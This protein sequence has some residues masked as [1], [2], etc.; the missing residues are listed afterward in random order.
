MLYYCL[1]TYFYQDPDST[2]IDVVGKAESA[3]EDAVVGAGGMKRFSNAGAPPIAST[4]TDAS[5]AK[6]SAPWGQDSA[7]IEMNLLEEETKERAKQRDLEKGAEASADQ[8]RP[9]SPAS[10]QVVP[11][12]DEEARAPSADPSSVQVRSERSRVSESVEPEREVK[13]EVDGADAATLAAIKAEEADDESAHVDIMGDDSAAEE[14]LL[15]PQPLKLNPLSRTKPTTAAQKKASKSRTG[16]AR[17]SV[18]TASPLSPAASPGPSNLHREVTQSGNAST[19]DSTREGT[20]ELAIR[21]GVL[22]SGRN[23][24]APQPFAFPKVA[25]RKTE[26]SREIGLSAPF[27]A[28]APPR[29]SDSEE[30]EAKSGRKKGKGRQKE[31]EKE[32]EEEEEGDD[33][34][35]CICQQL[36]DSDRSMIACDKCENWYHLDCIGIPDDKVDLVDQ[37]ICPAYPKEKTTWKNACARPTCLRAVAPL[38]KY[39]SD[40]CGIEVAATR[41][42]LSGIPP[43]MLWKK[44]VGARRREAVVIDATRPSRGTD[45]QEAARHQDAEDERLLRSLRAK[46][47]E[48]VARRGVLDT[49]VAL[50]EARL[51]YLRVAIK[52]WEQLC[53]ETAKAIAEDATLKGEMEAVKSKSKGKGKKGP[54][55]AMSGPGAQCG[56]DV[57]LCLDSAEWA[58][59]VES[60]EGR[61]LLAMLDDENRV[62]DD[63]E[64]TCL[65]LRKK[66]DRHNGWQKV[67]EADFE[68][69]LIVLNRRL[70]RLADQE[71]RLRL[72]LEDHEEASRFRVMYRN[73]KAEGISVEGRMN[74]SPQS[75]PKKKSRAVGGAAGGVVVKGVAQS[76]SA[77]DKE[78][79]SNGGSEYEIPAELVGF[80]SRSEQAKLKRR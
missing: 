42:E 39:C 61:A 44:V 32:E 51:Q 31:V 38:S 9:W 57:R 6:T 40:Y 18:Y 71:R 48:I 34:Q 76:S 33:R 62:F 16:K 65:D 56:F 36:Y 15:R 2:G 74:S 64:S 60:E 63:V 12:S 73:R 13:M 67:R 23:S 47:S 17:S 59:F 52:R 8:Q 46:L 70:K 4:S 80:L 24:P 79:S 25:A 7:D 11:D 26:V 58:V 20:P 19:D 27:E 35:Y 68:L 29:G 75:S 3:E 55:S 1:H 22:S 41:L 43:D 5:G 53:E 14:D 66:C 69:E 37:F 72:Q 28:Y 45:M 77:K 54:V 49:S 21:A 50:V 78:A 10:S 30:E